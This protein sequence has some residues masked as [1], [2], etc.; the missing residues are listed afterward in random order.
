GARSG[1][2]LRAAAARGRFRRKAGHRRLSFRVDGA[3]A[4]DVVRSQATF[5]RLPGRRIG[6]HRRIRVQRVIESERVAG[7][8]RDRVLDVDAARPGR[9]RAREDVDDAEGEFRSGAGG[10]VVQ[11]DVGVEDLAGETVGG[12]GRGSDDAIAVTVIPAV[13]G[14]R[15]S[16]LGQARVVGGNDV[17]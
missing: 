5:A 10:R 11:L 13:V 8:V 12:G 14:V 16:A 9:G 2:S 15:A 1:L 7:L 3:D 17:A 6:V 4:G